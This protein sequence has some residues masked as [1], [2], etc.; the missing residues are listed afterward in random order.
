MWL[1]M[2]ACVRKQRLLVSAYEIQE[3]KS[4]SLHKAL[5][6]S[7]YELRS[8]WTRG[9]LFAIQ[10][11]SYRAYRAYR[12]SIVVCVVCLDYVHEKIVEDA[13]VCDA[14]NYADVL[15]FEWTVVRRVNVWRAH[16]ERRL[17]WIRRTSHW[18]M[19]MKQFD[20]CNG[21]FFKFHWRYFL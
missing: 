14:Y 7:R 3:K 18:L 19:N 10:I 9:C 13:P 20:S 8:I 21:V 11:K 5:V 1:W 12:I 17:L 6:V 15:S 16:N 2:C 4:P